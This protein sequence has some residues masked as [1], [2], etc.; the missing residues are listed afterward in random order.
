MAVSMIQ[1]GP[2]GG[3]CYWC[4]TPLFPFK[5]TQKKPFVFKFFCKKK[6]YKTLII[7]ITCIQT[8][9]Y[10]YAVVNVFYKTFVIAIVKRI[11]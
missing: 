10:K 9:K 2:N 11:K 1:L 6:K 7:D 4:Q 5:V 8:I 3:Y